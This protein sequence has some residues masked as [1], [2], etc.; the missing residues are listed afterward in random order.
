MTSS[1]QPGWYADPAGAFELRW[2]DGARW[3]DGVMTGGVQ[4]RSRLPE[5]PPTTVQTAV[6]ERRPSGVPA[7]FTE[8][9]LVVQQKPKLVELTN[10]Y[11]VSDVSGR[12]LGSVVEVG[13]SWLRKAVRLVS[14]LDQFFSHRLEVRDEQGVAHLVL[15]R[16]PK[17]LRSRMVVERPDGEAVGELAQEN[18]FGKIRF[19][20]LAEGR[21]V[22]SLN[23]QNWRA[24]DFRVL[25]ASGTEVARVTKTFEG[26]A[27]ALF[28]TADN[29]VVEIA[30]PLE[31]PLRS[32]VVAAALTVDTALKQDDRG[33]GL[34]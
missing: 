4:S 34:G 3:T 20:L 28:T 32:L 30:R 15:V 6:G 27:R 22:G 25:D 31:E 9:V 10:E 2:W 7:L 18:V 11:A 33:L 8:R 14:E 5:R 12:S 16:P 13:Q 24:W 23:A 26:L 29:Y 17:F 1:P 21:Q 19:A